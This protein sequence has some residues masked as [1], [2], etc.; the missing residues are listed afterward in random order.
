MSQPSLQATPNLAPRDALITNQPLVAEGT[1]SSG[2]V[3]ATERIQTLDV[4]RGFALLG[5]LMVNM[6]FFA[7][8]VQYAMVHQAETNAADQ[9]ATWLV[10]WL[11][12]GKFFLFFSFLFGLG[13]TIQ[14]TRAEAKGQRFVPRYLR[15]AGVLLIFG[16]IHGFL[17]WVGDILFFYAIL[18]VLLIFFRRMKLK[19]VWTWIVLLALLPSLFTTLGYVAGG[20]AATDPAMQ[21]VTA[22]QVTQQLA[23]FEDWTARS[24]QVYANGNFIEI[25]QQRVADLMF[26]WGISLFLIPSIFAMFLLGSIFGRQ[27]YIRNASEHT[28]LF[29]NLLI[30]GGIIGL[31]GNAIYATYLATGSRMI[32][33]WN[34]FIATWGQ[35]IG[36]PALMLAYVSAITLAML[37]P[38]WQRRLGVLAPVGRMALTNYLLQSLICTT[39]FYGYG[40]GLF[41]TVNAAAGIALSLLIYVLQ[42][43]FSHWWLA[44]FQF[45]PMEWL[46]RTLTYGRRQP[47][48]IQ[49]VAEA[50]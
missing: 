8:P 2:P 49:R 40:F 7:H 9:A 26:M 19:W 32:I 14:M 36:A 44:R 10:R 3:A 33:D 1:A 31:I 17:I 29:R 38:T 34:T 50:G 46:W 4:L 18:G 22:A 24:Y 6:A 5:I 42:I 21:Q 39:I 43:P 23:F 20:A 16:L 48:R 41:G 12:D 45:G 28:G 11:A 13:F 47:F 15:R 35:G 30:W 37:H 25:T 27:G